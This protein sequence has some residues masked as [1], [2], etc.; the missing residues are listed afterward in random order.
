MNERTGRGG[1]ITLAL[2]V[3]LGATAVVVAEPRAGTAARSVVVAVGALA[4]VAMLVLGRGRQRRRSSD[5]LA[6]SG[7]AVRGWRRRSRP[8]VLAVAAWVA[9]VVAIAAFDGA[10]FSLASPRYPTLSHY[11]G[12]VTAKPWSRALVFLAYLAWGAWI[13]AG[14][15]E[16]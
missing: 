13:V 16:A 11:I 10:S 2:G 6:S 15:R 9:V 3:A 12:L 8:Q 5:W 1:A 14:W 7:R 4:L